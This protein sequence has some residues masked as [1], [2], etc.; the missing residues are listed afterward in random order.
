MSVPPPDDIRTPDPLAAIGDLFDRH[1]ASGY[2]GEAVTQLEHALQTATLAANAGVADSLVAAALLHDLGHLLHDLPEDAPDKGI[3]DHH[4]TRAARRLARHFGP[5]VC[6]P[7][8]L[9]VAA[10]RYLTA[11]E[12][13]YL[14]R[15][16][17][18]SR[19]S[20]ALQGGPM[21]AAEVAAFERETHWRE[22]VQLRRWDDEA[23][24]PGLETPPLAAFIDILRAC[25]RDR[26]AAG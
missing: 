18:P 20:L 15:L 22:A 7:V 3:D 19:T 14:A 6:D 24:V 1:G 9:H 5:D 13:D 23:K 25:L 16:S 12:P 4:E 21:A 10:K 26:P 17:A 11:V 2:G 8:R